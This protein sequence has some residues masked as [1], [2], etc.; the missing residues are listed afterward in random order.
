MNEELAN[1]IELHLELQKK[2][3]QDVIEVIGLAHEAIDS[4]SNILQEMSRLLLELE[5]RMILYE[6]PLEGIKNDK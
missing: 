5:T 4:H 1:V 2:I 3:N 6:I